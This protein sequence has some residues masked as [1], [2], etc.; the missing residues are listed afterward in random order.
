MLALILSLL[1]CS[2]ALASDVKVDILT[3]KPQNAKVTTAHACAFK[4]QCTSCPPQPQA[5][6]RAALL[7]RPPPC[8]L[9][10]IPW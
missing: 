7:T 4:Y 6:T 9:Q 5:P 3:A 10:M 8:W 2:S 1:A